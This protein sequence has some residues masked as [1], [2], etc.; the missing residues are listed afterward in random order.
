[1]SAQAQKNMNKNHSKLSLKNFFIK[2]G[3]FK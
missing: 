2:T 1:M 3:V